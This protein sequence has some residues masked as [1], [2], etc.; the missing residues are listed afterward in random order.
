MD[1]SDNT[2]T[3]PPPSDLVESFQ[4]LLLDISGDLDTL[5]TLDDILTEEIE[6]VSNAGSSNDDI[7]EEVVD[8]DKID[9]HQ[10]Q[11]QRELS[12]LIE[13]RL[14]YVSG[15]SI[16]E[17]F[18]D[19][20]S[21]YETQ[22]SKKKYIWLSKHNISYSFGGKTYHPKL[23]SKFTNI[24]AV[25]E[26]LNDDLGI[27][28]DSCLITRYVVKE[29]S[30]SL[31]QDNEAEID[32]TR[33]MCNISIGSTRQ[34]EFCDSDSE[35]SGELKYVINLVEGSLVIMQPGCQSQLWHKV[36]SV[37][38][39][40]SVRYS[41]SFRKANLTHCISH[42][43]QEV[44]SLSGNSPL[45]SHTFM[46]DSRLQ[47]I[48][49]LETMSPND[50]PT[51]LI[52]GASM[53][54]GLT[55]HNTVIMSKG[56]AHPK[57][58]IGLLQDS[59]DI[60][61]PDQYCHIKSVTLCVGTNAL[62]VTPG[63]RIPLISVLSDYDKLVCDLIGYFPKAHIG[64]FNVLPRLCHIRETYYRIK[65]FNTFGQD[66]ISNLYQNVHWIQLYWAFV[67]EVGCLVP[68]LYEKRF[69]HLS[70]AGKSMMSDCIDE[71]Q[72]AFSTR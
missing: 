37:A 62:N 47:I 39:S 64:L 50:I 14:N 22:S 72:Q 51:H 36:P 30:L 4:K 27:D 31:H 40:A 67:D 42:N 29:Q 5:K 65:T 61:H 54:K 55:N 26:K 38:H 71:F 69:L 17:V 2:P 21:L 12:A 49:N 44:T 43:T 34:I 13:H 63:R 60:L 23:I 25:I 19:V 45:D 56:G 15:D 53:T 33:P 70:S 59:V 58:I 28:L 48:E 18:P 3:T 32:Q 9:E 20:E 16:K 57:D 68:S 8:D 6:R 46:H 66:I 1:N 35:E 41:L 7:V 11:P 52:I 24:T 10:N